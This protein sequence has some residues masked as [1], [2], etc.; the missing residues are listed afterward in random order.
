MHRRGFLG[1]FGLGAVAAAMP[2]AVAGRAFLGPMVVDLGAPAIASLEGFLVPPDYA[3]EVMR[4]L[5]T[6]MVEHGFP[7]AHGPDF[8]ILDEQ[9][10]ID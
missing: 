7:A 2:A 3:A 8:E 10:W 6:P 4:C 9:D 5:S 1:L